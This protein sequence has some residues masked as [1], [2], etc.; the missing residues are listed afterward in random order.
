MDALFAVDRAA[1]QSGSRCQI[2]RLNVTDD[3]FLM[4][5]PCRFSG[6]RLCQG[7]GAGGREGFGDAHA[8]V[9]WHAQRKNPLSNDRVARV[10]SAAGRPDG[11]DP[12]DGENPYNAANDTEHLE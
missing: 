10:G 2:A 9:T 3:A 12:L 5:R 4:A 6:F 8:R 1:P 7:D 11:E